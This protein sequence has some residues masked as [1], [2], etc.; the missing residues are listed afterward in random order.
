MDCV[1][2]GMRFNNGLYLLAYT[3]T[4]DQRL[5]AYQYACEIAQSSVAL[6]LTVSETG[7]KVWVNLSANEFYWRE[8]HPHHG[9]TASVRDDSN[10]QFMD[11]EAVAALL[12]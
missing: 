2:Q 11:R 5:E 8:N 1:Q 4:V 9:I 6:A 10:R 3:F 7:Y 12:I